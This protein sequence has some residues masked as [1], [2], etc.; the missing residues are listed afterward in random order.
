MRN[1]LAKRA[2]EET[3]FDCVNEALVVHHFWIFYGRS[4]CGGSHLQR[5]RERKENFEVKALS[6]GGQVTGPQSN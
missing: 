3:E 2:F 4:R 5:F 1:T 6:V